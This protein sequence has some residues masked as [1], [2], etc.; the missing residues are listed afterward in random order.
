MD[1]IFE[2][3]KSI[4]ENTRQFG[5][6]YNGRGGFHY[7][8]INAFMSIV[9][10][11]KFRFSHKDYMNDPYHYDK[12]CIQTIVYNFN[13]KPRLF[14]PN[15]LQ[16]STVCVSNTEFDK[17]RFMNK[18]VQK[19][20]KEKTSDVENILLINAWNEWGE[21]MTF[22]PSEEYGYCHLNLLNDYLKN[23]NLH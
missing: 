15:R 11:G 20:D 17:I 1:S 8:S 5:D 18:I 4:L 6:H 9:A 21:K 16:H 3:M 10:S 7:T 2:R 14:K 22:E 13:N 12:K 19:Y 23:V